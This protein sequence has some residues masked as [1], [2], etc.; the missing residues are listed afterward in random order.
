MH[1]VC[2]QLY[3]ECFQIAQTIECTHRIPFSNISFSH[4][5]VSFS[6]LVP[7]VLLMASSLIW[8][9]RSGG[10]WVATYM[11]HKRP[12]LGHMGKPSHSECIHARA[13][14]RSTGYKTKWRANLLYEIIPTW[15]LVALFVNIFKS[16][17][18]FFGK[19]SVAKEG[20]AVEKGNYRSILL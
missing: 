2:A 13:H 16:Q 8:L 4:F 10:G 17:G 20:H 18:K 12:S 14:I 3:I 11:S 6:G 9:A 7:H 15:S 1:G 19:L 5:A